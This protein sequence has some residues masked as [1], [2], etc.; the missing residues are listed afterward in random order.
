M[1]WNYYLPLTGY[2]N[3]VCFSVFE[4]FPIN[5]TIRGQ[6]FQD[7]FEKF[8]KKVHKPIFCSLV[9]EEYDNGE[10][11]KE[12]KDFL[13][14]NG[15]ISLTTFTNANTGNLVELFFHPNTLKKTSFKYVKGHFLRL[16]YNCCGI[17][18]M[19]N[20]QEVFTHKDSIFSLT[21]NINSLLDDE[22]YYQDNYSELDEVSIIGIGTTFIAPDEQLLQPDKIFNI[23]VDYVYEN[24]VR[25][26]VLEYRANLDISA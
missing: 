11:N 21:R 20:V 22:E 24:G 3:Y 4:D 19:D 25:C 8:L 12:H 6:S 13:L 7:Y 5:I 17:R 23:L 9:V 2:K 10:R 18:S 1:N 26:R 15:F 16:G 14:K